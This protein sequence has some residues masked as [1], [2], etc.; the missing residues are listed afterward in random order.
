MQLEILAYEMV[1]AWR[2]ASEQNTINLLL[3]DDFYFE[4]YVT[5]HTDYEYSDKEKRLLKL[6]IKQEWLTIMG[7]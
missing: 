6:L 2:S 4:A 1:H 5:I 3:D 7:F